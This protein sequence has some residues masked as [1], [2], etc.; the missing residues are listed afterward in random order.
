MAKWSYKWRLGTPEGKIWA[1]EWTKACTQ[2]AGD[3][4]KFWPGTYL[5]PPDMEYC[6]KCVGQLICPRCG[7]HLPEDFELHQGEALPCCGWDWLN[8]PDDCA[9]WPSEMY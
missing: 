6:P 9:P 2:C 4:A 8:G 3:G 5:D 7:E 1:K